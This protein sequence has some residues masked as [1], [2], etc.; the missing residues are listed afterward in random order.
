VNELWYGVIPVQIVGIFLVLIFAVY[1]GFR[2]KRR[3][4]R[5]VAKGE[6]EDTQHVDVHKLVEVYE[7]DQEVKFPV[8]GM[9][10]KHPWVNWIN[11]ILT[12]AIIVIM[13]LN[14]APPEFAFM[15]GVAIALIV[16]FPDV[17]EQMNR[18]KAHAPNA[19]MMAAVIIAAGMFLG[20]LNETGMLKAIALTLIHIIPSSV[21]PYLHV[22]VGIFGVPLDLLTSTDAYYFAVLPIVEQTAGQFGVPSVSTAYSMLIGNIIGT[23]VSPF[24]PALWLAIGLAEANMGTY[25][26]Y[27]FFWIWGFAIVMLIIALLM[28]VVTV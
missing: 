15:I 21:G 28:G 19:L 8:R 10:V 22:I 14:I 18:L 3:I 9:A 27:A 26:K 12:L 5:A 7:R 13:L 17:D 25:I 1:L 11:V 2:E 24:S 6:L 20:V 23:F 4:N 16:N